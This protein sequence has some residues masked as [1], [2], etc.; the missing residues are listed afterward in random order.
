M[1]L[2]MLPR[3]LAAALALTLL[4]AACGD[5]PEPRP[6]AAEAPTPAPAPTATPMPT[7]TPGPADSFCGHPSPADGSPHEPTLAVS[8]DGT[9][10]RLRWTPSAGPGLAYYNVYQPDTLHF[11]PYGCMVLLAENLTGTT[12]TVHEH[13][14]PVPDAP[15]GVR[16][17][18]RTSDSLTIQWKPPLLQSTYAVSACNDAGCSQLHGEARAS[19]THDIHHFALHRSTSENPTGTDGVTM[20]I[21]VGDVYR[22]VGLQPSTVHFYEIRTCSET[23]CSPPREAAGLTE[24]I[25]PVD[26]PPAP[27]IR[28]EKVD[29]FL[30]TDD[31][32]V[33]WE[34]VD[35]ATYYEVYQSG[36]TGGNEK[37]DAEVSAPRT[38]YYDD[39]PNSWLGMFE[40]TSYRVKSCNK[41]GCSA[42]SERVVVG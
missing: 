37:L 23:E 30:F 6:T 8:R 19:V 9:T 27:D 26:I 7:A 17:T 39:S 18:G 14:N 40:S 5:E 24:A 11:E 25:G 3:I 20:E 12:H 1:R 15:R 21:P 29:V 28:G 10:L 4:L 22:D 41:A 34:A 36:H 33:I 13:F 35:G 42:F 32:R 31:A 16:V 38:S 2:N